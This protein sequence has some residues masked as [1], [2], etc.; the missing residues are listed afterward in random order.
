MS[1]AMQPVSMADYALTLHIV[2]NLA[3]LFGRVFVMVQK[4]YET[5]N[6]AFEID[7]V[8]PQCVIGVDEQRLRSFRFCW[9]RHPEHHKCLVLIGKMPGSRALEFALVESSC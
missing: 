1:E 9:L 4:G 3:N 7:I 2:Q 5:G 8:F 6:G